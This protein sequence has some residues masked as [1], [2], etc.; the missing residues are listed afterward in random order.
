MAPTEMSSLKS[1]NILI[2]A[3][4]AP[5]TMSFTLNEV[6]TLMLNAGRGFGWVLRECNLFGITNVEMERKVNREQVTEQY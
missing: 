6:A 1:E 3:F 2:F 5:N 4:P